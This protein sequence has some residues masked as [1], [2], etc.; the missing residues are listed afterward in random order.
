MKC[1]GE[2]GQMKHCRFKGVRNGVKLESGMPS[3]SH[4][5]IFCLPVFGAFH[6]SY[7]SPSVSLFDVCG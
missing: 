1:R 4:C 3:L 2:Y 6:T 7:I 5:K